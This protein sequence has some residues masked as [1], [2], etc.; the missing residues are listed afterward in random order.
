MSPSCYN[1]H[2]TNKR[3]RTKQKSLKSTQSVMH[4]L[5]LFSPL[6]QVVTLQV[7][8]P[9]QNSFTVCCTATA[10]MHPSM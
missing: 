6:N 7:F 4:T 2:K 10:V 1:V 3:S 5:V 8:L 9:T